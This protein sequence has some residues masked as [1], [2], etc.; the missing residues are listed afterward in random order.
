MIVWQLLATCCDD[1]LS[2]DTM[3]GFFVCADD[4]GGIAMLSHR[5]KD[6]IALLIIR[7]EWEGECETDL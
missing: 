6:C 4:R 1:Q 5:R 2:A 3:G 7:V